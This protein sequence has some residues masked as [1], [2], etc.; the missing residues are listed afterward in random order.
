MGELHN[1]MG[2][3]AALLI[4][5][6]PHAVRLIRAAEPSD[7]TIGYWLQRAYFVLQACGSPLSPAPLSA[8]W[9]PC[10]S[11]GSC[12]PLPR[13]SPLALCAD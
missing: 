6:A 2:L 3:V 10:E 13:S 9:L 8:V 5:G 12:R 7:A 4:C 1:L 11:P